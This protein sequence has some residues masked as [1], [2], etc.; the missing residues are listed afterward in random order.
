MAHEPTTNLNDGR[1]LNRLE[2]LRGLRIS[3][4]EAGFSTVHGALTSGAF[5]TG[6]AL[7]LGANDVAIGFLTAIPTFAGL[8]QILSSPF[9]ERL[10]ERKAITAWSSGA[11]RTLWLLIAL[12][13]LLLPGH[14]LVPFLLLF[15][16][17][18]ALLNI[19]VPAWM[20]WMSDL[21]PPDH[22]GR[23]FARRNMIAGIVGMLIGLPAAWFLD[24]ATKRH[25]WSALGFGTLFGVAVLGGLAS[26]VCLWLQPEPP[27]QPRPKPATTGGL[28]SVL[29]Y[30]RTPFADPNFR[31]LML[32][33]T[34]FGTGQFF[35]APF[36]N[37]YALRNLHFDYVWLQVFATI[38]SIASLA[39]MPMWGWLADKFGNKPLLAIGVCGVFTLPFT[40]IL[41]SADHPTTAILLMIELALAGGFFWAGVG[42]TQFNLL[43][44][45]SPP[46]KTPIYVATMAAVTGLMGGLSPLVGSMVMRGLSGWSGHLFHLTLLNYHVTFFISAML[47]IIALPILRPLVDKQAVATRDVLQQLRH[48]DLRSWRNLRQL[49]RPVDVESRL[50]ATEALGE[51]RTR[52]AVDELASALSDPSL[53][54]REEAARA[55][56][57]IG[58]P[59]AVDALIAALRDPAAGLID[60]AAQALARIGDRRA[61]SALIPLLHGEHIA[62][63]RGDRLAA[64]RALGELAGSDAVDALL[65]A[66]SRAGDEE[67]TEATVTALGRVGSSRATSALVALL[68]GDNVPHSL[69][70]SLVRAL[71]EIGDRTAVAV[72]RA[73]LKAADDDPL[74]IPPLADA[75]SRL[76]DV[77]SVLTLA[78]HME[79]SESAVARKQIAHAIGTL[80]GVGDTLYSLLS[81]DEFSRD[82]AVARLLQEMQR[83]H[84]AGGV[85]R[86]ALNT[87]TTGDYSACVRALYQAAMEAHYASPADAAEAERRT[88]LFQLLEHFAVTSD[89]PPQLE[90]TLL[91]I[92]ALYGL[93]E[94]SR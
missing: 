52:L 60:D 31:R 6:Y 78:N 42:L 61:N 50:R 35:A 49:Q 53:A 91:A 3:T 68:T 57:E 17:S 47:R 41:A 59:A 26:F 9:G 36:F 81:R 7:W 66:L 11:A 15:S 40:W 19:P 77:D 73:Q 82:T 33:N 72:L 28:R 62:T 74:L 76:G 83:Q 23:Y 10:R 30:Y 12:L 5:L 13:P 51:A 55:L 24:F 65:A 39:S 79:Q 1:E 89:R 32:F 69:R 90:T 94:S 44:S 80:L 67:F 71:G 88:A 38:T 37:V 25:P 85:L 64:V 58:D 29:A 22:R 48:A 14:A 2:V 56:G 63:T 27:M 4:T 70:M 84:K 86:T 34:I 20:S 18:F 45:L 21:V 8:I 43:I 93:R 16:L 92:A 87:Y 75:L 46:Q 54:V